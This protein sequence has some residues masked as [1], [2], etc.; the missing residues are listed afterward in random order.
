[1]GNNI[2][3]NELYKLIT[4]KIN[5]GNNKISFKEFME[6]ALY[7][8]KLGY[9]TKN[10]MNIGAEGDFYTSPNVHPAFGWCIA[11]QIHEMW[12]LLDKP[13]N[14][15]IME[16]GP[17]TGKLAGDILDYIKNNFEDFYKCI[18]YYLLEISES[19]KD[20]Q[21]YLLNEHS[22]KTLWGLPEKPIEG[23]V[24]SNEFFDALPVHRVIKKDGNLN[25]IFIELLNYKL[26]EKYKP[27]SNENIKDYLQVSNIILKEGQS[28]EVCLEAVKWLKK[29]SNMLQKGFLLTID[30]GY[31][32]SD[33][34]VPHRFDGTLNCYYKHKLV[35]NPYENLGQ[36]DI[37]SHVNFSALI[38]FGEK[39]DLMKSGYTNQMKFLVNNGIFDKLN[40]DSMSFKKGN[41][42]ESLAVKRLIMPEGMGESFKVLIQQKNIETNNLKA[43][44]KIVL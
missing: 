3:S 20:K 4:K 12:N 1:M 17:G 36:Q 10:E 35:S 25:E 21:K 30:Y 5:S 39:L 15:Y 27:L 33:L 40:I 19:L 31:L 26:E 32:S 34:D 22:K 42:K 41:E 29:I 24:F 23:V 13:K 7:H 43:L 28:I 6:L 18:R 2:K 9:Y 8:P 38:N 14:F 37:T 44:D 11:Q 16:L